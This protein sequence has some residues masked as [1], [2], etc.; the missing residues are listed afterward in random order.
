MKKLCII[1]ANCQ[2]SLIAEYLNKSQHFN[3]EYT[4]KRFSVHILMAKGTTIPESILQ[5]A[6]LFIYQP[7]KDIHGERSAKYLLDRL[8]SDCQKISFPSLYFKGYFPQ[9]CK[10]PAIKII[11]PNHPFGLIPHG[12]RNIV[13]MLK[14][15]KSEAEI[16]AELGDPNFYTAEFL[17]SNLNDTTETLRQREA[18][19]DIK[20]SEFIKANYQSYRLFYTQNHPT[21]VLG[22][23]VV[24][25]MLRLIGF[26]VLGDSLTFH[27]LNKGALDKEQIPIYP[28]V[29]K[30]L[31]LSFVNRYSN[32]IYDAFATTKMT[33]DRYISE[34][35]ELHNS[36]SDANSFYFEALTLV[37]KGK[38]QQAA[39][40]IERAIELKP[41]NANYYRELG[42]I[43]Q[44][45]NNLDRAETAY[46]TGIILSPDWQEFYQLLGAI[47]VKKKDLPKAAIVYQ[48]AVTLDP[49]NAEYYRLLGDVLFKQN[50]SDEANK[51]YQKAIALD[52][53]KA[54]YYRCLGD[55]YKKAGNLDLTVSN[56]RKAIAK[57]PDTAYFYRSLSMVLARQNKLDEA[58]SNCKQAIE[59]NDKN[60]GYYRTLGNIQLQQGDVDRAFE[61]YQQAIKLEPKQMKQIFAQLSNLIKDKVKTEAKSE[62]VEV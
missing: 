59:L 35:I 57:S 40:A 46:K 16:I 29:I 62:L 4:I 41:N 21:D 28:S 48:K 7:V 42:N 36:T 51:C 37:N 34:Y 39:K 54:Y 18:Q 30:H 33:F 6:R 10:N 14:E 31:N 26:P 55:V 22:M 15:G 52:P 60:P 20:V 13:E 8:P 19:L 49:R 45:Q 53:T 11:K 1:Y 27:N 23:Y 38:Y 17:R 9:L 44:Q 24:N 32:Y 5:Q 58:V 43:S 56:Y 50:R 3:R 12:D 61:A 2:N 47:L 25:Q